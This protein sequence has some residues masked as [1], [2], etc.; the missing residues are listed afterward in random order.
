LR[1]KGCSEKAFF[2]VANLGGQKVI[3]GHTWLRKHNPDIDWVTGEVKC[4]GVQ[5]DAAPAV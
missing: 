4:L 1:Y 5:T 3:M 2:A